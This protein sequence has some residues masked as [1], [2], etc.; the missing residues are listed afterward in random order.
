MSKKLIPL[1]ACLALCAAL[2]LVLTAAGGALAGDTPTG[3]AASLV[4]AATATPT[5]APAVVAQPAPGQAVTNTLSADPADDLTSATVDLHAGYIMDPY[6]LPVVGKTEQAASEVAAGCNGF[7]AAAPGVVVNW[8]GKTDQLSFFVYSDGDPVLAVQKPDGSFICNDD[9]GARTVEPL[10]TIRDPVAGPYKVHVGAARG[11]EPALGFLAITQGD[12]DDAKLADLDLSTMLRRRERP[13]LE[14]IQQ[15]EPTQL[16]KDRP[17]IFGSSE[18]QAGFEPM[19]HFAAGGGDIA[20]LR[21]E[22][23]RLVCAGNISAVPSYRFT[24]AGDPQNL[25]VY[26][27]ALKDTALVVITPDQ[28]VLCGMNATAA[29]LNPVVDIESPAPGNYEV[30]IA[31]MEPGTVAG[32]QLTIT[33]DLLAAPASLAPTSQ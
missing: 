25:R 22:D 6:L 23:Q 33:G 24:W 26:F 14:A 2:A 18:F 1:I 15:L 32:G 16:L 21:M 17:A 13:V 3:V 9:A 28:K 7:I 4:Q 10:V 11:D 29:N 19:Q 5:P 8:S 12:L 20:S 27:E 31:T 30:Y